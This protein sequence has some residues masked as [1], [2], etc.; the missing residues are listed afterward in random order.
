MYIVVPFTKVHIH[1]L[2]NVQCSSILTI[3]WLTV[4]PSVVIGNERWIKCQPFSNSK[5]FHFYS[6]SFHWN[7]I[8]YNENIHKYCKFIVERYSWHDIALSFSL[9]LTFYHWNLIVFFSAQ[10]IHANL[11]CL[12]LLLFVVSKLI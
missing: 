4:W 7:I 2:F 12:L 10:S 3:G 11:K 8:R 5:W 6:T 9:I 1:Y